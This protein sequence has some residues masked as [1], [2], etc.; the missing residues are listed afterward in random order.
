MTPIKTIEITKP[1]ESDIAGLTEM[2]N[3]YA[4]RGDLLPRSEEHVR[5]T[6]PDWLIGKDGDRVIAIGSLLMYGPKLA[7]VRSLAVSDE[8]QGTGTGRRLVAG[9][10]EMAKEREVPRVFALTRAVN[11]FER[12][13]FEITVKENFPEK[14]WNDCSICPIKDACD[15]T[16]VQVYLEI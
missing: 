13:G 16:A 8:V 4:K 15:E 12:V 2:I 7:E 11:F 5:A 9:L 3:E 14:V 1:A 6:L 10:I